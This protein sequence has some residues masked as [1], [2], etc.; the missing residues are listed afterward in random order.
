MFQEQ[1]AGE[2]FHTTAQDLAG[3]WDMVLLQVEDI[4]LMFQQLH[5]LRANGWM[6]PE[7]NTPVCCQGIAVISVR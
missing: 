7:K 1:D 3:F 6:T 5:T 2:P 4:D